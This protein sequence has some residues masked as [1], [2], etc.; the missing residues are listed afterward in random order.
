LK[1]IK[2]I[3]IETAA[4]NITALLLL[5]LLLLLLQILL[6]LINIVY[7]KSLNNL[8]CEVIVIEGNIILKSP[9]IYIEIIQFN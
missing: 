9:N 3:I 6:L 1:I 7:I 5:L 2:L 8:S 4:A